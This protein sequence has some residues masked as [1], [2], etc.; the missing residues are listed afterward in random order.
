[1][2]KKKFIFLY[3]FS[4]FIIGICIA[5]LNSQEH[6][7]NNTPIVVSFIFIIIICLSEMIVSIKDTSFSFNMMFW[8]FNLFFFGVAPLL[9]Y[10]TNIYSWNFNPNDKD[11]I[12]TNI[13]IVIW[14]ICYVFTNKFTNG[15][16]QISQ[17]N[18]YII[19]ER[20]NI[21]LIISILITL[22]YLIVIGLRNIVIRGNNRDVS[23]DQ[24]MFLLTVH[25]FHNIVL[26]TFVLFII[27]LQKEKKKD[28]RI[29]LIGVCFII[30]CFPTGLARNMMASFYVGLLIIL[31]NEKKRSRWI[32]V[33]LIFGLIL[34][35]PVINIFRN[36]NS[37][38]SGDI[39]N[40]IISRIQSEYTSGDYDAHQMF[41]SIQNA[42]KYY[43]LSYGKQ[44]LGALFFFIPRSIWTS[45]PYG[46]GRTAF[47][48]TSQ[49]WYTNVSAPLIS[50]AWVNFGIVGIVI[51][52]ILLG[53]IVKK[54]DSKYWNTSDNTKFIRI[55]YPFSLTMFFFIQRGDLQSTWAYTF[56]QIV[57][58]FFIYKFAVKK[59]GV[60]K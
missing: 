15:K 27:K 41:I 36:E 51:V 53:Y 12:N 54:L 10:W 6:I 46:T 32:S 49:H 21:L 29:Y 40:S 5:I 45:K 33:I 28:I 39:E 22:Y 2:S 34:I 58:F 19:D 18:S 47:E 17:S 24:T 9:Q 13:L 26:A 23:L 55:I 16:K 20:L 8:L 38:I 60:I 43:G 52:G 37:L 14:L 50:E 35:F 48:L 42:T 57:V 7:R 4:I 44:F 59:G 31:F 25:I 1:M 3:I 30:S 11:I 56:A